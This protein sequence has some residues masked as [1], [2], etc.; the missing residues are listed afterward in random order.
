[1][2]TSFPEDKKINRPERSI[3]TIYG[4]AE[5]FSFSIYNPEE[6]GSYIYGELTDAD[7]AGSFSVFKEKFFDQTFLSLPFR[8]VWIMNHT[9]MFVFVPDA[10]YKDNYRDDFMDFLLSDREGIPLSDSIAPAGMKVL[11]QLP[12]DIYQ[13]M[14]RSFAKPEFIHYSV[15]LITSFINK[16]KQFNVSQMVVNLQKT[17]LDIFCFSRDAFLFGNYFP[18][19]NLSE[20]IYYILFTWKQLQFNQLND[21]LHIT[22]NSIFK[23]DLIQPLAIYIQHIY[24][25]EIAPEI[26]FE[27]VNTSNI[28]F[29]LA[30]L[31]LCEL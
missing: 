4:G 12:E 30:A 25:L 24:F 18:Y 6:A 14:L 29:E 2:K 17:G 16:S 3:L 15:P 28:P 20:V 5:Q 19:K 10:F 31:S 9:P 27:G 7:H 21:Y 26:Y 1:M 8:K 22:G 11:Y 13:F 23:N